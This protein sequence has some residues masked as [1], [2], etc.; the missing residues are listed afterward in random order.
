MLGAASYDAH[1][2][3][4]KLVWVAGADHLN[5]PFI[6]GKQTYVELVADFV[7]QYVK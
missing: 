6:M 3:P 5:V 4:K 1:A 7:G 2:G